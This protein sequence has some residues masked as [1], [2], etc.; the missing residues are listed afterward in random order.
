MLDLNDVRVFE[1]VAGTGGFAAAARALGMPKSSVSRCIAR[2]EEELGARLFQRTTRDV[3]LTPAGEE[4]KERCAGILQR[5]EEAVNGVRSA[6]SPPRG[7]LR[8]SCAIGF[9]I[10]VLADELPAFMARYPGLKLSLDL[11]TRVV[12]LLADPVDVAVRLGPMPDSGLISVRL[13]A[14]TRH[15][16]AAPA[17]L[18]RRGTPASLDEL[19]EHDTVDMPGV[20]GRPRAWTFSRDDETREVEVVPRVRVNEALAL[21]KLVC[22][23]A[24]IGVIS[25]YMCAPA[26]A[27]QK[28]VRLLPEW[29]LPSIE[30]NIVF[31]SKRELDP[32]V[33]EFV[34]FMKEVTTPG[35]SWLAE[36]SLPPRP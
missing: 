28:L 16:C 13:G 30:V 34:R 6:T 25:G 10:N 35:R 27:S 8:V 24:G 26:F 31:P 21:H 12:D 11:T 4:L 2:L 9:G 3:A 32:N 14:M 36:P 29:S 20:D 17:Y 33:R 23:G 19:A 18:E 22:N 1:K 7:V 5:L 15:L